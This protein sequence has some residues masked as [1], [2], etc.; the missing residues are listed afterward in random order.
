MGKER[1]YKT[2]RK[3]LKELSDGFSP[4]K[5]AKAAGQSLRAMK[6]WA[7]E[8][9][10]FAKDWEDAEEAGT[11]SLEDVATKRA[12]KDSDALMALLL[13][14]RAPKKYRERT[15]IEH[16]GKIDLSGEKERVRKKLERAIAGRKAN[17]SAPPS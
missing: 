16:S 1:S 11:H 2:R 8:D 14:A 17:N 13:K 4:S 9:E 5:A 7:E 10:N 3:F 6:R 12:K 15:E